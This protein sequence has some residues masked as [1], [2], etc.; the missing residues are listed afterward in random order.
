MC[1][2][3][4]ESILRSSFTQTIK[5]IIGNATF[6]LVKKAKKMIHYAFAIA[7]RSWCIQTVTEGIF[8]IRI[9]TKMIVHGTVLVVPI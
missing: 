3:S 7:V 5:R 4:E 2:W 1:Y 8:T 9:S 6:V